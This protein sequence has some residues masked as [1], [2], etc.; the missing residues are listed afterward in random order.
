MRGV[1][2]LIG[3]AMVFGHL[4]KKQGTLLVCF[5]QFV[6]YFLNI[7]ENQE[8]AAVQAYKSPRRGLLK[9]LG[10]QTVTLLSR[11]E[12]DEGERG[13]DETYGRGRHGTLY[14]VTQAHKMTPEDLWP[15]ECGLGK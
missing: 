8:L 3:E 2:N 7:L 14:F 9:S 13:T 11:M 4:T 6:F 10:E 15:H 5:D 1:T 12:E